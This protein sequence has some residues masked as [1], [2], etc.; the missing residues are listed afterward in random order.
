MVVPR[1]RF[2]RTTYRL[3]GGCSTPEL[4]RRAGSVAVGSV[5]GKA[6]L[7]SAC[8]R[9]DV[10]RIGCITTDRGLKKITPR[11]CYRRADQHR[12]QL[13]HDHRPVNAAGRELSGREVIDVDDEGAEEGVA[14]AERKAERAA[15]PAEGKDL[16]QPGDFRDPGVAGDA[17]RERVRDECRDQ[18]VA[19]FAAQPRPSRA[20]GPNG[21]GNRETRSGS[22]WR[23]EETASAPPSVAL[24]RA[25]YLPI[26]AMRKWGGSED[27]SEANP[28]R[29]PT[30]SARG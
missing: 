28:I 7:Q 18:H 11:P 19:R 4:T 12:S 10:S 25:C 20:R 1:V 9:I 30:S 5:S 17:V 16:L 3:Q 14:A 27:R 22:G 13:I 2:E 6:G 24:A 15:A 26:C 23:G 29:C 21:E 8:N